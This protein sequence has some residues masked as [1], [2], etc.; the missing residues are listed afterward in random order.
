MLLRIAPFADRALQHGSPRSRLLRIEPLE[1]RWLLS[2]RAVEAVN[3]FALDVYEHLQRE[4]GNLFFSPLSI[5]AGLTMTYAGAAGQTAAQMEQVLHLGTEPGIH[6]SFGALFSSFDVQS[7][8]IGDYEISVANAIWPQ[9]GLPLH[10]NFINTIETDYRGHAQGLDFANPEQAE[11]IINAWVEAQTQGRIQ[12]LVD[13]LTPNTAMVLTNA[14][15]FKALWDSPFAP[16]SAATSFFRAPGD[17]I[18]APMMYGQPMATRTQ[19]DGFDI[20]DL[21]LADETASMVFVLPIEQN[22]PNHLTSEVLTNIE[23]WLAS[24]RQSEHLEVRLPKFQTTVDT[25]LNELLIGLG[26]PDAFSSATADFSAMTDVGVFIDKAFHKAFIEVN[27]QGTEAAAATEVELVACFSAGTPVLTSE[28]EKPIELLQVGD[29]VLARDE[30]NLEGD[31]QPKLVEETRRG[32]ANILELHVGGRIIRTTELHPFFVKGRGWISAGKLQAKDRLSTKLHDWVEVV[33]VV[34][35]GSAEAVYN[36]RVADHHTYFVGSKTWGFAVWTHNF[37]GT[38]FYADHPFHF[39]IRDNE[40]STITFMGRI[41]DP[42]QLENSLSPTAQQNNAHMGDFNNDGEVDEGDYAVWKAAFGQIGSAL[43]ADG[44]DNGMVDSADYTIWRDN[45]GRSIAA[46]SS[47]SNSGSLLADLA[48]GE[49]T[50]L[51]AD[52]VSAAVNSFA[53]DSV[54]APKVDPEALL[55]TSST[56]RLTASVKQDR[57]ALARQLVQITDD[58]LVMLAIATAPP[59]AAAESANPNSISKTTDNQ[60]SRDKVFA[61]LGVECTIR[62]L[63]GRVTS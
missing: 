18:Q 15:Y 63:I 9:L 11:D 57:L 26:M 60:P 61:V 3:Q 51:V 30:H 52:A 44:N 13:G 4:Q 38:G 45:L 58:D 19:I 5:S 7:A 1:D 12:N 43:S 16:H 56:Q 14:I 33:K 28:G 23:E 31:L 54:F 24:P 25:S 27:E 37:Y 42:S 47:M 21:P 50:E 48:R 32:E 53:E 35:T 20:L 10:S 40:S 8:A 41:D 6:D 46:Q 29:Y 36:L 49:Q 59:N 22:G 55:P 62:E 39:L 17:E 34:E 2:A